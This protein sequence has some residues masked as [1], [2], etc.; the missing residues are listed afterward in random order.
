MDRKDRNPHRRQ[1]YF[2]SISNYQY[3]KSEQARDIYKVRNKRRNKLT[4]ADYY[5]FPLVDSKI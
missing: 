1:V 4:Y 2:T 5:L 3:T